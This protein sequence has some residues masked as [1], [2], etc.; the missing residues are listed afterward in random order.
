METRGL[1]TAMWRKCMAGDLC[2]QA[3]RAVE[4]LLQMH[5]QRGGVTAT[6]R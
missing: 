5:L 1:L 3:E 6:L 4:P 2:G